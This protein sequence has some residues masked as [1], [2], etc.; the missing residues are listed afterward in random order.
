MH[1]ATATQ[2]EVSTTGAEVARRTPDAAVPPIPPHKE[3][4]LEPTLG[5]LVVAMPP[6]S[7]TNFCGGDWNGACTAVG[8]VS[9]LSS[10]VNKALFT[11]Q[12][13]CHLPVG[14]LFPVCRNLAADVV[15][16]H[17]CCTYCTAII[18]E[19]SSTPRSCAPLC[20]CRKPTDDDG[21]WWQCERRACPHWRPAVQAASR[22]ARVRQDAGAGSSVSGAVACKFV[23]VIA[24]S[25]VVRVF[26]V[27]RCAHGE[28]GISFSSVK[29]TCDVFGPETYSL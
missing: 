22:R 14:T 23:G 15:F 3:E 26:C 2:S 19:S 18:D 6:A 20:I 1:T 8:D 13:A 28:I 12:S 21:R 10:T 4:N 9:F 7:T 16:R 25:A 24:H 17:V 29:A 5:L 11:Q 27:W